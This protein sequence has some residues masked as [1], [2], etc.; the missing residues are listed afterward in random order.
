MKVLFDTNLV[1]DLLLDR[2]PFVDT[3]AQIFSKVERGDLMGCLCATTI[4][5]IYYLASKA[6]G[7]KKARAEIQKLL[8]LFE[9]APVNRSV[10]QA[11][12]KS[13]FSDFEDGVIH[14]AACFVEANGIVTRDRKGFKKS[15]VLIYSPRELLQALSQKDET[16]GKDF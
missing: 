8:T 4:T 1:L 16:V 9:I 5:T 7:V 13:E 3:V 6:V 15:R 11:A 10:L 14:E 2:E 12:L